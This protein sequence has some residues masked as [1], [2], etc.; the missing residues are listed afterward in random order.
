MSGTAGTFTLTFVNPITGAS[1]TTAAGALNIN[2]P[3]LAAD[4]QAALAG[5]SNVPA[6]GTFAVTQSGG[7]YQVVFGG[8]LTAGSLAGLGKSPVALLTATPAAGTD[9]NVVVTGNNSPLQAASGD[10]LWRGPVSLATNTSI[11]VASSARLTLTGVVDDAAD[12]A[13]GSGSSLTKL[14]GGGL[15]LSGANTYRGKTFVSQGILSIGN[16]QALGGTGGAEV[17]SLTI[18][19]PA[20]STDTFTLSFGG[21]TTGPL[22]YTSSTLA[23]DIQAALNN[24]PSFKNVGGVATVTQSGNVFTVTFGG[25]FAD[26]VQAPLVATSSSPNSTAVVA[27]V[28]VGYDGGTVVANGAQIQLQ[29][30]LTVAGES[31]TLAGT[32]V[33]TA[34]TTPL[35]WFGVGPGPINNAQTPGNQASTGR[36]TGTAVDPTDDNVIYVSTAGGGAW[37]TKDGGQDLAAALRQLRGHLQRGH[38]RRPERPAG[39]L[40]RHRRGRQLRRLLLRLRRL[41]V[42]RL[43]PHLDPVVNAAGG[44]GANPLER[45]GRVP[46][47]GGPQ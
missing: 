16:S 21:S 39:H 19:A 15:V 37:K 6:G 40:P 34:P 12:K 33:G 20:G 38:R 9:V 31:L 13:S 1:A 18:A 46:D 3:T 26:A 25:T 14:N 8:T 22:S 23:A 10:D 41:E 29:G 24:L 27:V 17:Q 32:G 44:P 7:V 2:S 28:A 30:S 47:R 5:L 36:I 42:H 45:R 11:D 35:R 43:G 4:I